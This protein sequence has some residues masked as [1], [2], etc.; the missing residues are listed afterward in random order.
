MADTASKLA[1]LRAEMKDLGI[2]GFFVPRADE[3]QGEYV[4]ASAERLAWISGFHGSAGAAII[5]AEP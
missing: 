3:F 1:A 2:D 4:P 5:L